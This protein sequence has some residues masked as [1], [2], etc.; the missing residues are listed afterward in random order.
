MVLLVCPLL[1]SAQVEDSEYGLW[2]TSKQVVDINSGDRF[3]VDEGAHLFEINNMSRTIVYHSPNNVQI[4]F[5]VQSAGTA[6]GKTTWVLDDA[7]F[8]KVV[9][10]ESEGTENHQ[11]DLFFKRGRTYFHFEKVK[12]TY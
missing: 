1:C 7:Y 9:F 12:K 2:C 5:K 10:T 4:G 11:V 6:F 3:K 8:D